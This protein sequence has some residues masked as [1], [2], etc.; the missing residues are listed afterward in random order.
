MAKL[1]KW[2]DNNFLKIAVGV[3]LAVVALLPKFPLM[4]IKHTWVYIRFEDFLVL[5]FSIGWLWLLA[6]K[7]ASIKSPISLV[8]IIYWLMGGLSLV[9]ALLF[10]K[11]A[12]ANFYPNVALLHYLR[13][14]EYLMVFFIALSAVK[15]TQTLRKMVWL[16]WGILILVCLYGFGQKLWGFPAFL[17]M[18]E[19]FAKGI[20]LRL[21]P[22]SRLTSTFAGHYDLA[23]WLVM[24]VITLF[25]LIFALKKWWQK[26]LVGLAVFLGYVLLLLTAS[27]VSFMVWLASLSLMLLW[28]K[29]KWLIVPGIVISIVLMNAISGASQRFGKTFRVTRVVYDA[30]TGEAIGALEDLPKPEATPTPEEDLPLGSGYIQIPLIQKKAPVVATQVA[31]IRKPVSLSLKTASLSS[32][33]ATISG[34]FLIRTAIV[35]DI[36][37]TTRIQGTWRRALGAFQRSPVFGTGYSSIE[38]ASDN[39]FLRALGETGVLGFFSFLGLI[40]SLGII[41]WQAINNIKAALPRSFLIGLAGGSVGIVLNALLIDVFEA[42]KVALSFWLLWGMAIGLANSLAAK[43]LNLIRGVRDLVSLRSLPVVIIVIIFFLTAGSFINNYFSGDDFTWLRWA[44]KGNRLSLLDYFLKSEGFFYR[45]LAKAYF[46]WAYPLFGLRPGGFHIVSLLWHFTSIMGIFFVAGRV[47]KSRWLALLSALFF[48]LQ[49][50]NGEVVFWISSTSHLMASTAYILAFSFWIAKD[51][52]IFFRILSLILFVL[53]IFSHELGVTLPLLLLLYDWAFR[54]IKIVNYL[55][56]AV[57]LGVYFW[58]RN[59]AQAL[60]LSGDY[61]YNLRNLPFNILGNVIGYL[62]LTLAGDKFIYLYDLSRG[63]W[64]AHKIYALVSSGLGLLLLLK[65][66]RRIRISRFVWFCLGWFIILLLPFLGLGNIA[67]RYLYLAKFG[68]ILGAIALAKKYLSTKLAFLIGLVI[69]S[70]FWL[71]YRRVEADW[72]KAG[73][74]ANKILLTLASNY[75]QF[76]TNSTLCFVDLPLRFNR[77]WVY[78]VGLDDAIWFIYQTNDLIVKK[79]DIAQAEKECLEKPLVYTFIYEDFELKELKLK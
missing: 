76:P 60:G 30:S 52:N 57:I 3:L 16:L 49:P 41:A 62:G 45:P 75:A 17:T 18:N 51:K 9:Y 69:L 58:V 13:R 77:A 54:K 36:S 26:I 42:S 71:E 5:L 72:Q 38:L 47:F 10:L 61:N 2:F 73:D 65:F 40:L 78:P 20:A 43:K 12:L 79:V 6:R 56:F 29:K 55:P 44:A 22:T 19:E 31:V 70:F 66:Y 37:F 46:T 28:Q 23:A 25:S 67:E 35:Y 32:E 1:L 33:F 64:R 27:R 48:M 21:S 34:E 63:Y 8:I 74:S 50:T 39:S 59:Y 4:D 15:D 14:I 68:V 7:K 53:A 24:I 11:N